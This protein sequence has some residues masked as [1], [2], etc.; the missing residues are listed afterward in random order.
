[1]E[2]PYFR[3]IDS[4]AVAVFIEIA[5]SQIVWLQACLES[6]EGLALVRTID[7][8][9]GVVCLLGSKDGAEI[10][11]SFLDSMRSSIP[12]RALSQAEAE[13]IDPLK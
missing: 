7:R 9:R 13:L 10:L 8:Q 5:P 4:K 2:Q 12:W 3:S 11:R 1:M 6:Y